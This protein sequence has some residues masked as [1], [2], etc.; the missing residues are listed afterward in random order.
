MKPCTRQTVRCDIARD[1]GYVLPE[2]CR[3][4]VR[5][6]TKAVTD[7]LKAEGV[8][9]WADYGT[10]MG[11]VRNPLTA[12]SDYPWLAPPFSLEPGIVPHDKDADI[13]VVIEDFQKCVRA[14]RHM[15][16]QHSFNMVSLPH[17]GSMKIRLSNF[18][19]TNIDI[20]YWYTREDGTMFRR[21]YAS[22]DDFK[23]REFPRSMLFPLSEVVWEGITLPAPADPEAFL[24]MRYGPEWRVPICANNDG[25]K[26]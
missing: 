12:E 6:V 21:T 18:N 24:E 17:R 15:C 2:C 11:A 23:G 25:V 8:T 13:G 7:V 5:T 16:A 9:F 14:L 26:R 3:E 1:Y 4:H 20:F 19:H 22:V 10:L